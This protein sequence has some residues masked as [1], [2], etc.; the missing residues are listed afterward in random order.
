MSISTQNLRGKVVLITGASGAIGRALCRA[1]GDC[2]CRL[3]LLSRS[4]EKL[5]L[6]GDELRQCGIEAGFRAVDLRSRPAVR[7][8]VAALQ[9]AMGAAD[10]LIHNA[11][12][13]QVTSARAPDLDSLEEMLA[14]NYLGGVYATEA[15]LPAMLARG[16]G[17]LVAIGSLAALRGMAWSAGYSASKAAFATFLE[18][19]RPALR[20]RGIAA[21]SCYLGFVRTPMSAA[22]PLH[23]MLL[24]ISPEAAAKRILRAVLRRQSEA[25]FPWY[26]AWAAALLRRLPAWAFDAVMTSFGRILVKREY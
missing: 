5:Q 9:D 16:S 10:I 23:P 26:D 14:V 17:Q 25:F 4:A 6:L 3:G 15:V 11:G 18:S 8:S 19:L 2:G 21:T 20:R 24:M 22:L 12:V 7:Q 13:G 1:L